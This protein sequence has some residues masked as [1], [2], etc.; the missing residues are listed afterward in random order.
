LIAQDAPHPAAVAFCLDRFA[1][2]ALIDEKG[3]GAQPNLH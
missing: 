1:L 3:V 2:G